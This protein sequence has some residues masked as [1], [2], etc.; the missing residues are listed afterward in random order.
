MDLYSIVFQSALSPS[1]IVLATGLH[2]N[3]ADALRISVEHVKTLHGDLLWTPIVTSVTK[4]EII[5][6]DFK[7]KTE[8]VDTDKI[9]DRNWTYKTIIENKDKALYDAMLPYMD[10]NIIK[11]IKEKVTF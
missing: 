3:G 6:K 9:I 1:R 11:Y 10:E 7:L 4:P 2:P 8:S 5:L